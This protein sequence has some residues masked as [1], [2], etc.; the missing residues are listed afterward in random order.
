MLG[1]M[2]KIHGESGELR[3]GGRGWNGGRELVS[4]DFLRRALVLAFTDTN[5]Q[6]QSFPDGMRFLFLEFGGGVLINSWV[7]LN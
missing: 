1:R 7:Y 6:I 4:L 3:C 2:S 5:Q